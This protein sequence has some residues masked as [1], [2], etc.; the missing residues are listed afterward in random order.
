MLARFPAA[1]IPQ[2]GVWV[3]AGPEGSRLLC[4]DATRA[5]E[6]ALE[7][8]PGIVLHGVG[9]NEAEEADEILKILVG[10]HPPIVIV[11]FGNVEREELLPPAECQPVVVGGDARSA[12]AD[13]PPASVRRKVAAQIASPA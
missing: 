7:L 1:S 8:I 10:D 2:G 5:R 12:R 3:P 4:G 13:G 9:G 6:L 11:G